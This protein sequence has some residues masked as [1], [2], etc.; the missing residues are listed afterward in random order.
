MNAAKELIVSLAFLCI[1]LPLSLIFSYELGMNKLGLVV[2]MLLGV[3][4][5]FIY[6]SIALIYYKLKPRRFRRT[7]TKL[8]TET[9]IERLDPPEVV[10]FR[11][12]FSND[13]NIGGETE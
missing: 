5:L 3:F 10:G 8:K 12:L 4:V 9:K 13:K 2:M 6:L 11:N 1:Y 7:K